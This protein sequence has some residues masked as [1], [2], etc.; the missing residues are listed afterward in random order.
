MHWEEVITILSKEI[1]PKD[2]KVPFTDWW[3]IFKKV[4]ERFITN[5]NSNYH[6]SNWAGRIKARKRIKDIRRVDLEIELTHLSVKENYWIILV[7]KKPDSKAMV[8]DCKTYVISRLLHL[9]RGD[10]YIVDKKYN[11]LAFFESINDTDYTVCKS[12]KSLTPFEKSAKN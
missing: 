10:F 5:E 4:E 1:G 6:F 9:H 7:D 11:W 12:G 3:Q 2:F 8:Y